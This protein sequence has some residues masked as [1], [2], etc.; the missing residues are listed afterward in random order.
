[1]T[2]QARRLLHVVL[3]L[4]GLA[5]II[6]GAVTKRYGAWIIGLIVAAVTCWQWWKWNRQ[7]ATGE[8]KEP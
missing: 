6:G 4:I 1:M 2:P 3:F 7:A 8:K 5:L